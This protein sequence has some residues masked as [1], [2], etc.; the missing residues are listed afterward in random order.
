MVFN[1]VYMAKPIYGGWVTMTGHLSLKYNYP[2][3]KITKRSEKSKRKFGYN[4]EYQN[5]NINDLLKLDNILITALDKHYYEFLHLFP[6]NTNI[7]IHDPNDYK[8]KDVIEFLKRSNIFTIRE[9]VNKHLLETHN[10]KSIFKYHPFFEYNIHAFKNNINDPCISISRIDFDKH[11]DIILRANP[12]IKDECNKIKIYGK[13]NRLYVNFKLKDLNF[14]EY[15]KG[16]YDKTLPMSYEDRDMLNNCK[17]VVD[18]SIIKN[19]GGGTQYTFLEA[20]YQNCI[21]ILHKEWVEKGELF[22][23]KYNCYVIGYTDCIEQELADIINTENIELDK[24]I[25]INSKEIMNNN[26]NVLW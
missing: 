10:I 1:L 21:L 15:W 3:Y 11:T 6:D 8:N 14:P 9:S 26:I 25:L 2:L 22:K 23:D 18:M 4:I 16:K 13:E 17:Y 19:D 24:Q 12:L 5:L 20:I 7:I